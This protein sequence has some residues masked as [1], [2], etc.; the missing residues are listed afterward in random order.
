MTNEDI[1]IVSINGQEISLI[2][3]LDFFPFHHKIWANPE[4]IAIVDA[5]HICALE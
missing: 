5:N 1:S 4:R 2:N 3:S